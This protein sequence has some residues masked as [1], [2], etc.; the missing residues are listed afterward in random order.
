MAR[1]RL[2]TEEQQPWIVSGERNISEEE[3]NKLRRGELTSEYRM[4]EPGGDDFPQL[5][6]LRYQPDSEIRLHSHD[7]D[8]IIYVLE[9]AMRINN[10]I[11]GPGACLTIPGGVFYGFHAGPEGLRIL[12]FRPR[13]DTTFNLPQGAANEP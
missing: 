2:T 1:V 4:R 6:E 8:E 7:E 9:G 11:V 12:N 5:V 13:N 3:R 10:R